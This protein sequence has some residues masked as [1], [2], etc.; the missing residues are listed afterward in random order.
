MLAIHVRR[1]RLN[2]LRKL[3][4]IPGGRAWVLSVLTGL[5]LSVGWGC[6]PDVPLRHPHRFTRQDTKMTLWSD[7]CSLQS[8]FDADPPRNQIV[9]ERG[10]TERI[11]PGRYRE[12]GVITVRVTD[13]RQRRQLRSLLARYYRLPP[14]LVSADAY[15]VTLSTVRICGR[16]RMMRDSPVTVRVAGKTLDLAFHPCMGEYLLNRD[17]Y[18]FRA[19]LLRKGELRIAAGPG[20]SRVSHRGLP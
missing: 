4:V 20:P 5:L 7:R 1:T 15:E 9:S 16:P 13:P 12:R 3:P 10:W 18:R 6:A 14:S 8:F 11:A 2:P 19:N 17:L